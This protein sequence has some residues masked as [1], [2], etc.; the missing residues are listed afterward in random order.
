[1]EMQKN[2]NG[3]LSLCGSIVA[4]ICIIIYLGAL[5]QGSVRI[6]LS[7]EQ[8]KATAEREF[9]DLFNL[10]LS[11]GSQGFLNEQYIQTMNNA[12]K[13][14]IAI[15]A[16]IIT[17][18]EGGQA[19]EKKSG[20]AISWTNSTPRF[21]KKFALSGINYFMPL[22]FPGV[23]QAEI[24]AIASSFDYYEFSKILKE[25]LI[26]IMIGLALSFF[27]ILLQYLLGKPEKPKG[28]MVYV[29]TPESSKREKNDPAAAPL[30][31]GLYSLRSNIGF[32]EYTQDRLDSELHRC[33]STE[34]DLALLLIEFNDITNDIMFKQ[35]AEEAVNF[36]TSRDLLFEY[37]AYG[38]SVI[39]P[40]SGF[41]FAITRAEKFYQRILE[42]FP[43]S[44]DSTSAIS[45]GL[46]TRSGRL[47]NAERLIHEAKE[48]LK[49]ARNDSKTSIIAFKSDPEKYRAFIASQS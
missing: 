47:L 38:I 18:P 17:G 30:P 33:A 36:F 22:S 46:S 12:L 40:G 1:M 26:I 9:G 43:N 29:D 11:S 13:S 3:N 14:K 16:L 27:T 19:I 8:H 45:I 24:K 31:K 44:Y 35:A 25:T 23:R 2:G 42:K 10:A 5:I 37:G 20:H 48:A 4:A 7:V 6:Y 28:E 21:N 34:K 32:E 39:L 15:E 49:K 41:D